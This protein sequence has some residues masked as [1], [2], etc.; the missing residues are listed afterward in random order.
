MWRE[1]VDAYWHEVD[2]GLDVARQ[3]D[4]LGR[5]AGVALQKLED[6]DEA[7]R[8]FRSVLDADPDHALAR[9]QL[10]QVL[11]AAQ[12]WDDLLEAL[13]ERMDRSEDPALRRL[14]AMRAAYVQAHRLEAA[15]DAIDT[16]EPVLVEHPEDLELVALLEQ[17]AEASPA[18]KG[19]VCDLVEPV[20]EA[21]AQLDRVLQIN[22]WRLSGSDDPEERH[23]LYVRMHEVA[24]QTDGGSE[25]A[26]RTL[27]R[28][29]SEPGP[30]FVL[31]QLDERVRALA[32]S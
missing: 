13:R 15:D 18:V 6:T 17:F 31:E 11:E 22:E 28:G 1:L 29:L 9:D 5:I 25:A 8:A 14:A 19:R 32:G 4:L 12:R 10:E 23:A 16:I 3:I 20:L 7:V 30:A 21:A 26:F 24:A 27:L 2:G